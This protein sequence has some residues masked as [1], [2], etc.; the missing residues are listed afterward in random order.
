MS[1]RRGPDAEESLDPL[2][3]ELA[4]FHGAEHVENFRKPVKPRALRRHRAGSGSTRGE[5]AIRHYMIFRRPEG[6]AGYE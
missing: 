5:G 4:R 1:A 2:A 6:R 3:V